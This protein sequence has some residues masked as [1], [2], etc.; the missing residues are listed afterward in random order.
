DR[1]RSLRLY[2]ITRRMPTPRSSLRCPA[3]TAPWLSLK[4]NGI[5]KAGVEALAASPY[6]KQVVYLCLDDNPYNPREKALEG[7]PLVS[8]GCICRQ[9]STS[10][11]TW[12][13]SHAPK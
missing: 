7:G 12:R 1:P 8:S 10:R 5:G 3:L 13:R 2:G 11:P 9:I 4:R 6:L